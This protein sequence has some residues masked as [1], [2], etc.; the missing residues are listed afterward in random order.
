MPFRRHSKAEIAALL[1]KANA[2]AAQGK[3]QNEIADALGISVM[4]LH[5]W[6]KVLATGENKQSA[7]VQSDET[8]QLQQRISE[9][10]LENLR[11]RQAYICCLKRWIWKRDSARTRKPNC[12]KNLL[13]FPKLASSGSRASGL[14][15]H[16][17]VS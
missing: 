1:A 5:R 12:N 7:P 15:P 9:L 8:D 3:T 11:L 13:P 4:T 14:D 10:Q 17:I 6:R 2:M 16:N